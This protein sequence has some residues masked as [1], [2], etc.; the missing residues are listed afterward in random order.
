MNP[1]VLFHPGVFQIVQACLPLLCAHG[2]NFGSILR[3]P[4]ASPYTEQQHLLHKLQHPVYRALHSDFPH[5]GKNAKMC[6]SIVDLRRYQNSCSCHTLLMRWKWSRYV[7]QVQWSRAYVITIISRG[8]CC[9]SVY[10][11][12]QVVSSFYQRAVFRLSTF[13]QNPQIYL[14]LFQSL[15]ILLPSYSSYFK[16]TCQI[17]KKDQNQAKFSVIVKWI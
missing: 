7:A 8:D 3:L 14:I 11:T 10:V 2:Y 17:L 1:T 6:R 15:K 16:D 4:E 5:R 12:T 13:F 9:D